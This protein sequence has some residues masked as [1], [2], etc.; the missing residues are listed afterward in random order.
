MR[1]LRASGFWVLP[2]LP[3]PDGRRADLVAL[4]SDGAVRIVEIK[5]SR[6]DFRSDKKWIA[7]PMFC[8]RFY[9]AVPAGLDASGFPADA[10]L[11]TADGHGGAIEREAPFCKLAPPAR[12]PSVS[13]PRPL[14]MIS[15][16]IGKPSGKL[17]AISTRASMK[18]ISLTVNSSDFVTFAASS[19]KW[20]SLFAQ[21]SI[22]EARECPIMWRAVKSP[23]RGQ[24]VAFEPQA[25]ENADCS[26]CD[27]F[28]ALRI[29]FKTG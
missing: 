16:L 22:G 7:Y 14:A 15:S 13:T 24:N 5:S 21:M 17:D 8:D 26:G 1:L 18:R 11:I 28:A 2:E 12:R 27:G 10:G 23:S 20:L 29:E 3:L 6:A 25:C 19:R 9:F 4:A